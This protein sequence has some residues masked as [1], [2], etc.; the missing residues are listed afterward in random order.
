MVRAVKIALNKG[1]NKKMT[2]PTATE[3]SFLKSVTH[4]GNSLPTG[5]RLDANVPVVGVKLVERRKLYA[6]TR[7]DFPEMVAVK[8]KKGEAVLYG[9][10]ILQLT[11]NTHNNETFVNDTTALQ[12]GLA[13]GD[14][15][16][17]CAVSEAECTAFEESMR[18]SVILNSVTGP[19]DRSRLN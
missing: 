10:G 3:H 7:E 9:I 15:I 1:R 13:Q 5:V 6:L 2:Q 19:T 8:I 17:I 11:T 16:E 12:L 14:K 18:D 4:I